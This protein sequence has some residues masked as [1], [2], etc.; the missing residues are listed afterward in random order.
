MHRVIPAS[1]DEDVGR[2]EMVVYKCWSHFHDVSQ[3]GK[4][5]NYFSDDESPAI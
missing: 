3:E 2:V 4:A 5:R 1:E